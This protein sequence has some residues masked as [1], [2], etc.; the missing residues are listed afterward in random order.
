MQVFFAFAKCQIHFTSGKGTARAKDRRHAT[1][2]TYDCGSCPAFYLAPRSCK[3]ARGL[4]AAQSGA[5]R[6]APQATPHTKSGSRFF[7]TTVLPLFV[8]CCRFSFFFGVK[9]FRLAP[10]AASSSPPPPPPASAAGG[11]G[12]EDLAPL[13]FPPAGHANPPVDSPHLR[14][15]WHVFTSDRSNRRGVQGRC[16]GG[17]KKR[18]HKRTPHVGARAAPRTEG[19][20]DGPR[21]A[22]VVVVSA[23][24]SE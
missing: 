8:T 14:D 6:S 21:P 11:G 18:R 4:P 2:N 19:W 20:Q 5:R 24:G 10:P 17:A 7:R 3:A 9:S 22:P 1:T 16:G 15:P 12:V 23:R 13:S